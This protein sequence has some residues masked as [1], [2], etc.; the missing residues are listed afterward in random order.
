MT[1][2]W[3]FNIVVLRETNLQDIPSTLRN[4]ADSIEDGEYGEAAGCVV[5]LDADQLEVFYTGTGE[6]APNAHLLL[7]AGAGKMVQRVLDEKA[8]Q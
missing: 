2:P 1:G 8:A 6:A 5:V 7:H 3:P 4:I